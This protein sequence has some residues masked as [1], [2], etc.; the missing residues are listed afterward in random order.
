MLAALPPCRLAAQLDAG[1]AVGTKAPVISINDLD[2]KPVDLGQYLGKKPVVLEFWATWCPICADLMPRLEA[3]RAKYGDRV[4]VLGVNIAVNDPRERVRRYLEKHRPPFLP[5]YD[6]KGTSARAYDVPTT[7]FIVIVDAKGVVA[8]TGSGADQELVAEVGKV[9]GTAQGQTP[10]RAG[11]V[12]Q[13]KVGKTAPELV[14]GYFTAAGPGPAD[15]PFRLSAELGR[16]LVL[17][18]GPASQA[19][20]WRA[21]A[22]V[23]DSAWPGATLVGIARDGP[24]AVAELARAMPNERL[25]LLADSGGQ[26]WRSF[27]VARKERRAFVVAD[28]GR[29]VASLPT[30]DPG[31]PPAVAEVTRAVGVG[32]AVP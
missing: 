15:Q 16:V 8:Y 30:F 6:D 14:L 32:R 5:F 21:V 7:G 3:V 18:F 12:G 19:D 17:V 27:G 11:M 4:T 22:L 24:A 29:I 23:A 10:V 20:W 13:A 28:D 2:G 26:A 9:L 25:K 1:I 31:R